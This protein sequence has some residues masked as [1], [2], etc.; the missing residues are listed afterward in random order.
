MLALVFVDPLHLH[1]EQGGGIDQHTRVAMDVITQLA[2][3]AELGGLPALEEA[4][5]VDELLQA[6]QLIE[7][8]NPAGANRFIQQGRELG[9]GQGHPA[10]RGDAVGDIGEFLGP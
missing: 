10:P 7:M 8:V 1:I 9:I 3:N 6:A 4:A 5:V 2:L